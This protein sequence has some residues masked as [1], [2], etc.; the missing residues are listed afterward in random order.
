MTLKNGYPYLTVQ[1]FF[2]KKK[3]KHAYKKGET[4]IFLTPNL[5]DQVQNEKHYVLPN[6][7]INCF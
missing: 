5:F 7:F 6:Q 2:K 1:F 4:I 3:K